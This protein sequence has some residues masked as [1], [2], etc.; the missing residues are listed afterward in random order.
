MSSQN[1]HD[2]MRHVGHQIVVATY[3][4]DNVPINASIE[5]LDCN[6]VLID[7]EREDCADPWL[8]CEPEDECECG[9]E[10]Q[11]HKGSCQVEHCICDGFWPAHYL[12]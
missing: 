2:L 10:L 1:F 11:E 9:H 12:K 6:E 5:C 7:F 8:D 4:R 3:V